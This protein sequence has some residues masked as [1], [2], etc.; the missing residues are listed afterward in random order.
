MFNKYNLEFMKKLSMC[1][2]CNTKDNGD[3]FDWSYFRRKACMTQSATIHRRGHGAP[4][5]QTKVAT[6][7][8]S[9]I[10]DLTSEQI[11]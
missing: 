5:F 10:N 11:V 4:N 1:F 6:D 7:T 9:F 2:L 8:A 3:F